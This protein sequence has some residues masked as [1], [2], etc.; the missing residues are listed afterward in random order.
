MRL[1]APTRFGCLAF[2]TVC[3][4][5]MG[6]CGRLDFQREDAGRTD[7]G[8]ADAGALDAGLPDAGP[9]DAGP[10]DGGPPE[11]L[12][13]LDVPLCGLASG[14]WRLDAVRALAEINSAAED[15]EPH[16]Q[17]DGVHFNFGSNRGGTRFSVYETQRA[18]PGAPFDAPTPI[19]GLSA[20]PFNVYHLGL[21]EGGLSGLV[22]SVR[23]GG[24][25]GSD[26][27]FAE[28]ASRA[29]PFTFGR[30]ATEL[31]RRVDEHDP[32]LSADG[33]RVYFVS[34][35]T[36]AGQELLFA[37]RA[38]TSAAFDPPTVIAEISSLADDDNPTLTADERVILFGSARDGGAG[39]LDIW[40]AF[41]PDRGSPFSTPVPFVA[42]NGPGRENEVAISLDGCEVVFASTRPGGMGG[43]DLYRADVRA[44]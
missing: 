44:L 15:I 28:R 26:L 35:R 30:E 17:F 22:A 37:E 3:A 32:W 10:P 42:L 36:G 13:Y 7:A 25:G 6:G 4:L 27:Y 5:A 40:I 11:I 33:L 12:E 2:A 41:R 20:R 34:V 29:D 38:S 9:P 21:D 24:T 16:F 43:A 8:A 1:S 31:D 18:T 23:F 14:A 19:A 39:G